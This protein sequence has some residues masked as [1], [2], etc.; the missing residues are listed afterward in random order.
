MVNMTIL[1]FSLL[2]LAS[3]VAGSGTDVTNNLFSDIGPLLALFGEKFAQQFLRESFTWLD[4]IIF[5][6]APLGIITAIVG[7]IRVGGPPWLKAVIGRARE[8]RSSA[9]LEFMSSTSHEVCELWNGEGIVRTTGKGVVKQIVYLEGCGH[10]ETDC[11]LFTLTEAEKEGRKYMKKEGYRGPLIKRLFPGKK[12]SHSHADRPDRAP[13]ISLN[14]HSKQETWEL[15]ATAATGILLQSGVLVFSAFVAYN[16]RFGKRVGGPPS[17]YAYPVLLAGTVTLSLG[18][19]ISA[20]VIGESTEEFAWEVMSKHHTGDLDNPE[21]GLGTTTPEKTAKPT[22][23]VFWLQKGI[24]VSDQSFDSFM[25]MAKGEKEIILTSCR[26]NDPISHEEAQKTGKIEEPTTISVSLNILCMI[27]TLASITGFILQFEGFR[28]ISWACSIAQLVAIMIMTILRAAVRRGMLDSPATEKITPEYEMDWL[29]LKLGFDDGYLTCLSDKRPKSPCPRCGTESSDPSHKLMPYPTCEVPFWKL[30]NELGSPS[31]AEWIESLEN[32]DDGKSGTTRVTVWESSVDSTKRPRPGYPLSRVPS[33]SAPKSRDQ[34]KVKEREDAAKEQEKNDS[35]QVHAVVNIRKRLGYLTKWDAPPSEYAICIANAIGKVMNCFDWGKRTTLTWSMDVQITGDKSKRKQPGKLRLVANNKGTEKE[36]KWRTPEK[37]I[38]AVLSLWMYHFKDQNQWDIE[39]IGTASTFETFDPVRTPFR[40]V[41]GPDSDVLKADLAWWA[42]EGVVEGLETFKWEKSD[43]PLSLGYGYQKD[44]KA[45]DAGTP[46]TCCA[47]VTNVSMEQF[48]AQHIFSAFMWEIADHIPVPESATTVDLQSQNK[49]NPQVPKWSSLRLVNQKIQEMAKAVEAASLGTLEDA[50][51]LIIPP[52]SVANKLPSEGLVEMVRQKAIENHQD[53]QLDKAYD[54]YLRLLTLCDES[55]LLNETF[56]YKAVATAVDFLIITNSVTVTDEGAAGDSEPQ[57]RGA[58]AALIKKL[59][60]KNLEPISISLKELFKKQKRH[61]LYDSMLSSK[62]DEERPQG[63]I[64]KPTRKDTRPKQA[65]GTKFGYT[66][67]HNQIIWTKGSVKKDGDSWKYLEAADILGWTPLHYAVIYAPDIASTMVQEERVLASRP[68]LAGRTPLHYA[69]MNLSEDAKQSDFVGELLKAYGRADSGSDGILPLHLAAKC[70]NEKAVT[71]LLESP[72]HRD[73]MSAGDYWGMTP[74]HFAAIAG[75]DTI[76]SQLLDREARINA[77]DKFE[78]TALHLAVEKIQASVVEKLLGRDDAKVTK[79]KDKN[80]KTALQIAA[81]I[82]RDVDDKLVKAKGDKDSVKKK[83]KKEESSKKPT[84]GRA[85]DGGKVDGKVAEAAGTDGAGNP[86]SSKVRAGII[87]DAAGV[88]KNEV[89]G[90]EKIGDPDVQ[91][92]Q[93]KKAP[94]KPPKPEEKTNRQKLSKELEDLKK[95]IGRLSEDREDLKKMIELLLGKEDLAVDGGKLLLWAARE[96]LN[97]TFNVLMSN[98]VKVDEKDTSTGQYALH[99][100]AMVGA[101]GMVQQLLDK[102]TPKK[103]ISSDNAGKSLDETKAIPTDTPGATV[104]IPSITSSATVDEPL[105]EKMVNARDDTGT[106]ALILTAVGGYSKIVDLL[107]DAGADQTIVDCEQR[108]AL[109]WAVEKGQVAIVK[110]LLDSDNIA[111]MNPNVVDGNPP[112]LLLA[113]AAE[114]GNLAMT[115]LLFGKGAKLGLKSNS[116]H[117][118]IYWAVHNGH[119]DL[120]EFFLQAIP[121]PDVD[122]YDEQ[123]DCTLLSAAVNADQLEITKKLLKAGADVK[124]TSGRYQQTPLSFAAYS[125][126]P[127]FITLLLDNP[128]NPDHRADT[129]EADIDGWT[130]LMFAVQG[131]NSETAKL[132]ISKGARAS[133]SKDGEKSDLSLAVKWDSDEMVSEILENTVGEQSQPHLDNAILWAAKREN[134][135]IVELLLKKGANSNANAIDGSTPML[136][137]AKRSHVDTVKL[138][139]SWKADVNMAN[140]KGKTPLYWASYNGSED[141]VN[142]LLEERN[143]QRQADPNIPTKSNSTPLLAAAEQGHEAVATR[144]VEAGA[145]VNVENDE[146]ETPLY[147]ACCQGST[148][149]VQTFLDMG[150]KP[151][152]ASN[153]NSTPL[154][155]AIESENTTIVELLLKR[156]AA[157]EVP[158]PKVYSALNLA[159]FM[160][161]IDVVRML[162]ELGANIKVT[163][164]DGDTPLH[165]AAYNGHLGMAI[166]LLDAKADPEAKN[167]IGRSPMHYAAQHGRLEIIE[168]LLAH[169]VQPD[170]GDEEDRTPISLASAG[171]YDGVIHLLFYNHRARLESK[172]RSGRSPISWAAC[173]GEGATVELLSTLGADIESE[174]CDKR[175]PLSWAAS[176]ENIAAANV[177]LA[178]GANV[179]CKDKNGRTALSWAASGS[180]DYM[181]KRLLEAKADVMSLDS[182]GRNPLSW[183]VSL[184]NEEVAKLLLQHD[185]DIQI[186]AQ[187][188]GGR[189]ALHRAVENGDT[190]VVELI[191][192]AEPNVNMPDDLQ[193][194]PLGLAARG[195]SE[196]VILQLLE[197]DANPNVQDSSKRTPLF[198][199]IHLRHD[200][201]AL[202][203]LDKDLDTEKHPE[204]S[205]TPLQEAV[206]QYLYDVMDKLLTR[207]AD[208]GGKDIQGRDA[209]HV[210]AARG[211]DGYLEL[212]VDKGLDRNADVPITYDKQGRHA[213]HHAACSR[214]TSVVAY[215]LKKYEKETVLD[216]PDNDGWTPLHWAAKA[217]EQDVV[218]QFLDIGADANLKEKLNGWSPIQI[219][220][221]HGR[222]SVIEKLTEHLKLHEVVSSDEIIAPGEVDDSRECDGCGISPICGTVYCCSTCVDFD[223]CFKCKYTSELTHPGHEF[224]EKEP[225]QDEED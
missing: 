91:K 145:K 44:R 217:G 146:N 157:F 159:S 18:M 148:A 29:S 57:L 5:A 141:T 115:K 171:G 105:K 142:A 40:R 88:P 213:L 4:H 98:G 124:K 45:R 209:V 59:K 210:V 224:T 165:L 95:T 162:L 19:W 182:E 96:R 178:L 72:L 23:R 194:T 183:A 138:L 216:Q 87:D 71:A 66:T 15:V 62:D 184:G 114:N 126:R 112:R 10:P 215:L 55:L 94:H 208:V 24:F 107:L 176:K 211:S 207:G 212:L 73:K 219:A 169:S 2:F 28:G 147:W 160:G 75:E 179:E 118:P 51:T 58:K 198:S 204:F 13:N 151:N 84:D 78:R 1:I 177:L 163:D 111:C 223:F 128:D 123:D 42:G 21:K 135:A 181:V 12:D 85:T 197:A 39:D 116:D 168:L 20:L 54:L 167:K 14:L 65:Y 93:R 203:M 136:K 89:L 80:G 161:E 47:V 6:M 102:W 53:Y 149:M 26:N 7:A 60:S 70:G 64:K 9:E 189:T 48:L 92:D 139:L 173:E 200:S 99:F 156:D 133:L 188:E 218:Q 130:P 46:P 150:A 143:E 122:E 196:D 195:D 172:D 81:E 134:T 3:G 154:L 83:L 186:S 225:S 63:D 43:K 86:G 202:K 137:A 199:A 8:N 221:F 214:E 37:D 67:L 33:G 68:D 27:G 144:L 79:V 222:D 109:S 74:L 175:T 90:K 119:Q 187:D 201:A 11:F 34:L 17:P 97:T 16:A 52:L 100:A 77:Q 170:E 190:D 153:D 82:E 140:D 131:G 191:L 132:L 113:R 101:E 174:D 125:D 158:D 117:S 205:R 185:P 120:V 103:E 76:I 22:F 127:L 69:V 30:C 180:Q 41:L 104:L 56:V 164:Q 108:T 206:Y 220:Q 50:Y 192:N 35:L 31:R 121:K 129:E 152:I 32:P 61:E 166:L 193:E 25:L 49:F 110:R 155:K 106:T 38:E 36:A